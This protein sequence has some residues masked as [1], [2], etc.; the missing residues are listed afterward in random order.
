MAYTVYTN[1]IQPEVF[2]DYMMERSIYK[3]ALWQSGAMVKIPSIG[4][5]LAQGNTEFNTP[6]WDSIVGDSVAPVVSGATTAIKN[7]T[8]D[9]FRTRK[10]FEEIAYGADSLS[11][12]LSGSDPMGAISAQLGAL[13]DKNLQAGVVSDLTGI[14]LDNIANDS[15][16]I[17]NDISGDSTTTLGADSTIDTIGLLGDASTDGYAIAAMHSKVYWHLAK[18]DLITFVP[19]SEQRAGFD[20]YLGMRVI[21]DDTLYNYTDTTQHYYTYFLKSGAIGYGD[22]AQGYQML[23]SERL[24][25]VSGGTDVIYARKC[26]ATQVKGMDFIDGSVANQFP[27][28]AERALAANWDRKWEQK[29]MPFVINISTGY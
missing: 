26:Y 19:E 10:Q 1:V 11:A 13:W 9:K 3:T 20:T 5:N 7:I 14:A 24:G 6:Y 17:V 8:A 16:D 18:E 12:M 23:E 27:T 15:S 25:G 22:T 28:N 29:N 2:E 21:V 4:A